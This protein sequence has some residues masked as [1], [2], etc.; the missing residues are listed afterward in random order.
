M[1]GVATI[2]D[3]SLSDGCT[4][5]APDLGT[6]VQACC[7]A[8]DAAYWAGGSIGD[9]IGSNIALAHCIAAVGYTGWALPFG[10]ATTVGGW[11]FWHWK[12]RKMKNESR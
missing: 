8:H 2:Y 9:W 7:L 1:W 3:P 11:I 5:P 4:W 12:Q 10:L 6:A